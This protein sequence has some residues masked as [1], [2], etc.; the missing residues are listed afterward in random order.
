M[1][2]E[3]GRTRAGA[4]TSRPASGCPASI[5]SAPTRDSEHCWGGSASRRVPPASRIWGLR[6]ATDPTREQRVE[7]RELGGSPA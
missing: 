7:N 3:V 6:R 2:L 4:G 5:H 1:S